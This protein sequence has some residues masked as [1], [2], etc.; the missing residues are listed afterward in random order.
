MIREIGSYLLSPIMLT[1]DKMT[2]HGRFSVLTM[3]CDKV[4]FPDPELPAM[5]MML[6]S[7]HGGL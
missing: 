7:A 2:T 1:I 5:P 3:A 4:D 6:K